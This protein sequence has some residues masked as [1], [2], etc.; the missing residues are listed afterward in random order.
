MSYKFV[1]ASFTQRNFVTDFLQ[2]KCDFR[3]KS[4]FCVFE[5]PL[6]DSG[7]THDDNLR[8]IENRVADFL[9]VLIELFS[10]GV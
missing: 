6:G 2:A 10:L 1:A 8:F 9:L 7:A 5:P 3:P 4:P